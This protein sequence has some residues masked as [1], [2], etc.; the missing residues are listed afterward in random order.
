[1]HEPAH[2]KLVLEIYDAALSPQNWPEVLLK[3]AAFIG[4]AGAIVFEREDPQLPSTVRASHMSANYKAPVLDAYLSRFSEHEMLDQLVFEQTSLKSDR[5]ELVSDADVYYNRAGVKQHPNVRFLVAHGLR[6]RAAALLDKDNPS[7]DRFS[8]QFS[9]RRGPIDKAEMARANLLLPHV[10]KSLALAR[11][12]RELTHNNKIVLASLNRLNIGIAITDKRGRLAFQNTEFRRI[13]SDYGLIVSDRVGK[14]SVADERSHR[15]LMSMLGDHGQH[16]RFGAR[17]RK[18][19]VLVDHE[20]ATFA[21]C[22]EVLPLSQADELGEANLDGDVIYCL[23]SKRMYD[24]DTS[25][26]SK[27]FKLT[28]S[29]EKTLSMLT[30]VVPNKR[31]ADESGKSVETIN[32]QVKALLLKTQCDNRTQLVRLAT[33][34]GAR[35]VRE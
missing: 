14:I 13:S 9:A 10:A 21:L 4:A 28:R 3:L 23:D 27:L 20:D 1:M 12:F 22:V 19:A 29:E 11:P 35:M 30:K 5:I 15:K 8:V 32:T 18:E 24:V 33:G 26:L 17:P 31:I 7:I 25:V 2:D 16:G 6:N 34:I